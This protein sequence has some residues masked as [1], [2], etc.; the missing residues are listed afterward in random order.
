MSEEMGNKQYCSNMDENDP[1]I[2]EF[3]N[4]QYACEEHGNVGE[5]CPV[6]DIIV[7]F[8]IS[9]PDGT[10]K[11]HTCGSD[12]YVFGGEDY[13][14]QPKLNDDEM[15]CYANNTGIDMNCD[16]EDEEKWKN[17]EEE[18]NGCSCMPKEEVTCP[19]ESKPIKGK[20][21]VVAV[22]GCQTGTR[23]KG[24]KINL[25]KLTGLCPELVDSK[26]TD[27]NGMVTFRDIS[28]GSY[29]IV[30]IIDKQYFEKPQ[31]IKWNEVTID[32]CNTYG[33]VVA[34]NKIK[35]NRCCR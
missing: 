10:C 2:Q 4:Q 31:Y 23:L 34:I 11:A 18:W 29:R 32:E 22:L 12:S 13:C 16:I 17:C 19:C 20:I 21:E 28:K 3:I 30:E 27:C 33:C 8:D 9:Y 5:G 6:E 24:V 35:Q 26:C 1:V 7:N 15:N 14:I 25:Y